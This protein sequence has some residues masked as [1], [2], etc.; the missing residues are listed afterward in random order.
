MSAT[1]ER[2]AVELVAAARRD[3]EQVE[4]A[5]ERGGEGDWDCLLAA[6]ALARAARAAD[7]ASFAL[8]DSHALERRLA[9]ESN[10]SAQDTPRGY[11]G[12]R[13]RRPR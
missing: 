12:D 13:P 2:S 11:N 1:S 8:L 3:L 9:L 7:D 6:V 4:A 5:L 10:R